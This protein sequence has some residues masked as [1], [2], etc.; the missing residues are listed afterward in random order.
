MNGRPKG[1]LALGDGMLEEEEK[2]R[3]CQR[4]EKKE[5]ESD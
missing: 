5:K 4:E 2:E 1:A 3:E